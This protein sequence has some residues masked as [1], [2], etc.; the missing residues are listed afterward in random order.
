MGAKEGGG[1]GREEVERTKM[2]M[3][4]YGWWCE[5]TKMTMVE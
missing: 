3:V 5:W 1:G 4:E 2:A